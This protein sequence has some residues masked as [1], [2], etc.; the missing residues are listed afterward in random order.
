MD[1]ETAVMDDLRAFASPSQGIART[2]LIRRS[3]QTRSRRSLNSWGAD[4]PAT[5][6]TRPKA[7]LVT[8]ENSSSLPLAAPNTGLG[9]C[10]GPPGIPRHAGRS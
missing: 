2:R 7:V 9:E 10:I 6:R 8:C 5:D 4:A 3:P 1:E